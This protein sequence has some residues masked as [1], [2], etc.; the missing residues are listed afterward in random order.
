[1]IKVLLQ[2]SVPLGRMSGLAP[3]VSST[4]RR[5]MGMC[6]AFRDCVVYS[7]SWPHS[8]LWDVEIQGVEIQILGE[9]RESLRIAGVCALLPQTL[10]TERVCLM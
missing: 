5:Q 1:M 3:K 7:Q 8:R 6:Q 2:C 4:E 10:K 9:S